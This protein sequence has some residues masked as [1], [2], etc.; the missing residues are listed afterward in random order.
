VVSLGVIQCLLSQSSGS[1]PR[2]GRNAGEHDAR[3]RPGAGVYGSAR[4]RRTR[5]TLVEYPRPK[6]PLSERDLP[7]ELKQGLIVNGLVI[8]QRMQRL[9]KAV[10]IRSGGRVR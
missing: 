1:T 8:I 7:L 6:A 2:T 10:R 5:S 3:T 4:G 9:E